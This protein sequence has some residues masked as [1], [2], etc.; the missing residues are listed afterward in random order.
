MA[1][2][3]PVWHES[4]R[5]DLWPERL[6]GSEAIFRAD[7]SPDGVAGR[8]GVVAP[9]PTVPRDQVE[10]G[11]I[12]PS[13]LSAHRAD[14]ANVLYRYRHRR[15][16]GLQAKRKISIGVDKGGFDQFCRDRGYHVD[17]V[18]SGPLR[19]PLR[20]QFTACANAAPL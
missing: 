18:G 13:R 11:N 2:S 8:G 15:S 1:L 10:A 3:Y 19:Q 14:D 6:F 16:V 20:R 17:E 7:D 12:V 5:T 4:N 9:G